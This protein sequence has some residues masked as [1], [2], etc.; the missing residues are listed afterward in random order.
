MTFSK[1]LLEWYALHKRELPWRNTS[2]PYYIWLSEIIL[3]Q[4]RVQQGLSYYL[5]FI[6]S[7]PTIFDL[8]N[9]EEDTILKLWQGLGYYSRARNLHH[10]A[11]DIVSNRNGKFPDNYDDILSLKGVGPYTAAAIASFAFELPYSVLDGNV[12]RVLSRF[13]GV[14]VP[15]DIPSGKKQ[16]QELAQELIDK[17][18]ASEYNQAIMEFGAI[19]CTPKRVKCTNCPLSDECVAFN[20]N[21]VERLPVRS[22]RIILKKRFIHYLIIDQDSKVLFGKRKEGI[23][24]GLYEF[25]FLE[26]PHNIDSSSVLHSDKWID[27]FNGLDY[28]VE[29]ISEEFIHKL[30]H[31]H[32]YVRFWLVKMRGLTLANYQLVNKS[33]LN[34]YPVSA[35]IDKFLEQ[36]K[37]S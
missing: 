25:P 3:Q 20:N 30:S 28:E 34:N 37:F 2:D 5:K 22:K 4:T 12:I 10:S 36:I 27:F 15:F 19:Q 16:F 23:W 33:E 17:E 35:L 1:T 26:F 18:N 31:Q 7:F 32:I 6:H 13:F 24:N 9:A 14:E 11:K 21:E 29:F 8:A